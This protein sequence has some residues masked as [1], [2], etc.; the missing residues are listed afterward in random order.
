VPHGTF[1]VQPA[2][3]RSAADDESEHEQEQAIAAI[4]KGSDIV[5]ATPERLSDPEFI[6]VLKKHPVDLFVV[7][8]AHCVSQWGHDFRPAFL[9]LGSV[10]RKLDRPPVLA[11]TATATRAVIDDIG[12]QLGLRKPL[13][14]NLGIYRQNLHYAVEH[15]ASEIKKQQTIVET[16]RRAERNLAPLGGVKPEDAREAMQIHGGMGYMREAGIETTFRDARIVRIY[17]GT[18]EIQRNIIAA[19]ILKD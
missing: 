9:S 5:F 4:G 16:L 7:D 17:E 10:V 1:D 12:K 3:E 18:S 2:E 13:V 19:Q 6:A 8:E 14:V 15:T 11:L